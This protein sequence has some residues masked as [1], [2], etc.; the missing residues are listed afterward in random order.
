MKAKA[1]ENNLDIRS[2]KL[3]VEESSEKEKEAFT[4]FFPVAEA[5]GIGFHS[6]NGL[7][8]KEIPQL[9][10]LPAMRNGISGG[11]T[12]VQ[13]IF[14][15]GEIYQSNHLAKVGTE[16]SR[17]QAANSEKELLLLIDRNF[18]NLYILQ[19]NI[20]TINLLDSMTNKLYEEVY[21]AV[22]AG[23][24]IKNEQLRVQLRKDEIASQK[25]QIN[26]AI[27]TYKSVLSQLM[28]IKNTDFELNAEEEQATSPAIEYVDHS[29]ALSGMD[30]YRILD[31]SIEAAE[32]DEKLEMAKVLPKIGIGASYGYQNLLPTDRSSMTYF[33][34]VTIPLSDW[35]GNSHARKQKE[36]AT[37]IAAYKK[38]DLSQKMLIQMNTLRDELDESY[39]Q[40]QIAQ[41]SI[42]AA[43][44]NLR[45]NRNSYSAGLVTMSDLLESQTLYQQARNK[46]SE[47]YA[48]YM[49]KRAEYRKETGR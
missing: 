32:V 34:Q 37:R 22:K 7:L 26:N 33:V 29:N 39:M 3:S 42:R 27:H 20:K 44:E 21:N 24:S 6:P 12:V 43:T 47:S 14:Q 4:H 8:G 17:L 11:I 2:I 40:I 13:P 41:S 36:I 28:G 18:W 49:I 9:F 45:I 15:G 46:L 38:Q 35:W 48:N 10:G 1:K 16:I 19:E 30:K 31:K 5:Q 25:L 23:I